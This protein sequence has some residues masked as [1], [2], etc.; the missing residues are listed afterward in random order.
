[1]AIA[2]YEAVLKKHP[3]QPKAWMSYGHALKAVGRQADSVAAYRRSVTLAPVLGEAWWSLANLKTV[4]F[5]SDDIAAMRTALRRADGEDRYHLDFA[6]GKA[7]EDAGDYAAAF[8]HYA[9]G[10]AMRRKS[11]V[12]DAEETSDHARRSRATFTRDF[13]AARGGQ[14]DPSPDPIFIVG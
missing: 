13:F 12:Y 7:L 2:S 10:N 3:G 4:A 14:G 8:E 1:Q 5:A 9:A 6:L 11:V